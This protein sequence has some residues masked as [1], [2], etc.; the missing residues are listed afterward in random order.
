M[1]RRVGDLLVANPIHHLRMTC[2]GGM[3]RPRLVVGL[4]PFPDL[5]DIKVLFTPLPIPPLL[6]SGMLPTNNRN[7]VGAWLS[8]TT[9]P[10]FLS[11]DKQRQQRRMFWQ[12]KATRN[13]HRLASARNF[14]K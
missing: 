5:L 14:D 9:G 13:T 7:C 6:T 3:C 2:R 10:L 11:L 1:K 4:P 8:Y 12:H